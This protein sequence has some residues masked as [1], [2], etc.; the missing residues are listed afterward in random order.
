MEL[1]LKSPYADQILIN[2][3]YQGTS[4]DCAPFTTSTV[5]N[6]FCQ[7]NL[8]A[9][10]LAKKMNKPRMR[11]IKPVIRRIPNWATFPWGIVDVLKD[12]G[13]EATWHFRAKP[14]QLISGL[15]SG[16]ILLPIIGE[17]RP[18]PWAHVMTLIAWDSSQGWGLADTQWGKQEIRWIPDVEF[19]RKWKNYG[20]L[21]VKIPQPELARRKRDLTKDQ[22]ST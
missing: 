17:W 21:V 11:G 7:E 6:T 10:E 1:H 5:V 19:Q 15:E 20:N 13:L 12:Y 8:V 16:Q 4:N 3:Q 2:L 18:R 22:S 14:D 9:D